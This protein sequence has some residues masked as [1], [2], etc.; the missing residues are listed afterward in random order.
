MNPSSFERL[1]EVVKHLGNQATKIDKQNAANKAHKLLAEDAIFSDD[2][3]S[4]YS[5]KFYAYVKEIEQKLNQLKGLMKA[6]QTELA[7]SQLPLIEQQITALLNAFNANNSL[8]NAAQH[9]L[10]SFKKRRFRKAAQQVMST[11][12]EL[13]QKLA[14]HREFERRLAEMIADRERQRTNN[15]QSNAQQ[16]LAQEVLALHQ[17]IGR[18]RQAISKIERQIEM[19]EK[20]TS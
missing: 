12:H 3:F 15:S 9:R 18:C 8:H 11:S 7:Y 19:A 20:R 1:T 17:R 5:D 4:T 13:H 16:K 10:D 6:N 14:E 2:L